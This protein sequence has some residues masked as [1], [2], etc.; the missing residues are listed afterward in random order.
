M[1][2]S[3]NVWRDDLIA[4]HNCGSGQRRQAMR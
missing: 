1:A 2:C 3:S 4:I